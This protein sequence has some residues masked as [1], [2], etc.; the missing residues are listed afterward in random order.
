MDIAALSTQIASANMANQVGASLLNISK[1]LMQ[2]QGA[3]LQQLMASSGAAMELSINPHIGGN[4]DI[5]L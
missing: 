3:A 1:D 4:I 5:K 2:Q